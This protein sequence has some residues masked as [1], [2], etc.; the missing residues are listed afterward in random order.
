MSE[1]SITDRLCDGFQKTVYVAMGIG[2]VAGL[3]DGAISG[4]QSSN[5]NDR[6]D[7][8]AELTIEQLAE[9]DGVVIQD[10]KGDRPNNENFVAQYTGTLIVGPCKEPMD[11]S[12]T[13]SGN[14][15]PT[16]V[17]TY[18]FSSST[19]PSN[20]VFGSGEDFKVFG[21]DVCAGMIAARHYPDS[22]DNNF[23][24]PVVVPI[25]R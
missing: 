13:F 8:R 12:V 9:A 1:R 17:Q 24:V 21:K 22:S 3:V 14:Q 16:D 20:L 23:P 19:M 5:A 6:A 11:L 10:V 4:I 7:R 15:E 2:V 25:I 18:K